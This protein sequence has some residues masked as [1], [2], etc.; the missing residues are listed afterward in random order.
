MLNFITPATIA[1]AETIVE[2]G[3]LMNTTNPIA[4]ISNITLTVVDGCPPPQVK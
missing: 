1:V 2:R 3:Q 4:V